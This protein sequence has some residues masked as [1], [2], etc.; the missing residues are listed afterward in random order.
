MNIKKVQTVS[1]EVTEN[2]GEYVATGL[3]TVKEDGKAEAIQTAR[4][5][6]DGISV[7]TFTS[8]NEDHMNFDTSDAKAIMDYIDVVL[9]F[10]SIVRATQFA[11]TAEIVSNA[12][13]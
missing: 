4:I 2:V 1:L 13:N 12:Q 5:I 11:T 10:C 9:E 3:V 8:W 7:I 6:K